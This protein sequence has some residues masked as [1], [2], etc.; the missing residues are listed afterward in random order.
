MQVSGRLEE[1]S[2]G[3]CGVM[4]MLW[5][6]VRVCRYLVYALFIL[7]SILSLNTLLEGRYS[8]LVE[9]SELIS[10]VTIPSVEDIYYFSRE[11]RES[12]REAF[13]YLSGGGVRPKKDG[14]GNVNGNGL[15]KLIEIIL[16]QPRLQEHLDGGSVSILELLCHQS[17]SLQ[18]GI[19]GMYYREREGATGLAFAR[20][21]GELERRKSPGLVDGLSRGGVLEMLG[22]ER[23]YDLY[24]RSQSGGYAS[25]FKASAWSESRLRVSRR[26]IVSTG[27][28][29][30][31]IRPFCQHDGSW[32]CSK[33]EMLVL[34]LLL[35]YYRGSGNTFVSFFLWHYKSKIVDQ[36][37][38]DNIPFFSK[39]QV[40]IVN[41]LFPGLFGAFQK[42]TRSVYGRIDDFERLRRPHLS[43]NDKYHLE[44]VTEED[45]NWV[46]SLALSHS[47]QDKDGN[48]AFV[49]YFSIIPHSSTI[50][51][52]CQRSQTLFHYPG[53][54]SF[55]W[56]FS[57]EGAGRHCG[58][59]SSSGPEEEYT[60][61][62]SFYGRLN[63][64]KSVV[65]YGK[66]L[67][68]DNEYTTVWF[69][70]RDERAPGG[71]RLLHGTSTI[72]LS[73][74]SPSYR[75]HL[76]DWFQ[77]LTASHHSGS[78]IRVR[79][80]TQFVHY[81]P[82]SGRISIPQDPRETMQQ[83][84]DCTE[85]T[86]HGGAGLGLGTIQLGKSFPVGGI[87]ASAYVCLREALLRGLQSR[88]GV[89][90]EAVEEILLRKMHR[91]C[92]T[93]VEQL[94]G[95]KSLLMSQLGQGFAG[96]FTEKGLSRL[97][98]KV[99]QHLRIHIKLLYA[100]L[101]ELQAMNKC[102]SYFGGLVRLIPR[103]TSV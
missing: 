10:S 46:I 77:S 100:T 7:L 30:E 102:M 93:R 73:V 20:Y 11:S 81:I 80:A 75:D 33:Y 23:P 43:G 89:S 19:L 15:V 78:K 66:L 50:Q 58:P 37:L 87:R 40:E 44:K 5:V 94:E 69:L 83:Y 9:F 54:S 42:L 17:F 4:C 8:K 27:Y 1:R 48:I 63:S 96:D 88:G 64:I 22:F 35:E 61:V 21:F 29:N 13:N 59:A 76:P 39:V 72:L 74:D 68:E 14:D 26:A 98:A 60:R 95:V 62:H 28:G 79:P 92:K 34:K 103:A 32:T 84:I 99:K 47:I 101:E 25:V 82:G 55:D 97:S 36:H 18:E 2:V 67:E 91:S 52:D 90:R 3:N 41:S 57:R 85:L 71:F 38:V 6:L 70:R 12:V 31:E 51:D 86:F 65:Q 45:V 56:R 16:A 53:E 24:I 49:P